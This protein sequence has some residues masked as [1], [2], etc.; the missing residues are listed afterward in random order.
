VGA[1]IVTRD[2]P[3]QR[4]AGSPSP[5]PS[6]RR[7]RSSHP[8]RDPGPEATIG[9]IVGNL[10]ADPELRFT[11]NGAAVP[12]SAESLTR[13]ESRRSP[14]PAAAT[15]IRDPR[16]RQ[17]HRRQARRRRDRAVVAVRHREGQQGPPGRRRLPRRLGRA[18]VLTP[19]IRGRKAGRRPAVFAFRRGAAPPPRRSSGRRGRDT[20]VARP[21]THVNR[22]SSS[23]LAPASHYPSR[24]GCVPVVLSAAANREPPGPITAVRYARASPCSDSPPSSRTQSARTCTPLRPSWVYPRDSI[25][26]KWGYTW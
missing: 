19:T 16:R 24:V 17:T 15:L 23:S 14:G 7:P 13:G 2:T 18:P 9:G 20:R 10:T 12:T 1:L 25:Q 6:P 3:R 11:P 5:L 4:Y 8:T 26:R 21:P 22:S